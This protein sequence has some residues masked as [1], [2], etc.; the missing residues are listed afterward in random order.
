MS[1]KKKTPDQVFQGKEAGRRS[2]FGVPDSLAQPY[3]PPEMLQNYEPLFH[4]VLAELGG[5][6]AI[7]D[8]TGLILA[9]NNKARK[10]LGL[11]QSGLTG[12][13]L[14]GFLPAE[15]ARLFE[16]G[17]REVQSKRQPYDIQ[18]LTDSGSL[19]IAI[20]PVCAEGAGVANL[21]VMIADAAEPDGVPSYRTL[22]ENA[23]AA[24]IVVQDETS[25]FYNRRT[26]EILGYSDAEFKTV[27]PF[28]LIHPEDRPEVEEKYR[29]RLRG[30]EEEH[31]YD[32]RI[33]ARNGQI[34][35]VNISSVAFLWQGRPA[36]LNLIADVT[37][38]KT[39]EENMLQGEERYRFLVENPLYG[40]YIAETPSGGL[41]YA[42]QRLC[43][44][45]GYSLEE[46]LRLNLDDLVLPDEKHIMKQ[47]MLARSRGELPLTASHVFT[48]LKKDG[49]RFR[50][51]T[52]SAMVSY[53]GKP[54]IQGVVRDVTER[55]LLEKQLQQS[56]KM[57]ALGTLAG[58]VAH[59]F[60]NI[61]MAIRGYSQ[62][63]SMEPELR[64]RV[65]EY[66]RKIDESTSR[67]AELTGR[68]LTFSRTDTGDKVPVQINQVLEGVM[69]LIG[70]TFPV[71]IEVEKDLAAGLPLVSGNPNQLQQVILNLAVN[72]RDAMPDGGTITFRS[73]RA[74]L[75]ADF[76]RSRPWAAPGLYVEFS[77]ED[78]GHGV[79]SEII[80]RIF[81]PF[82]T[83]KE[84]GRGTGLGLAVAYAIVKRHAGGVVVDSKDGHGTRFR[85]YF[86][87]DEALA[88]RQ[89]SPPKAECL[90]A[91]R[92]QRIL[93]V[94]DEMTVREVAREALVV[95]GY[96][97]AEASNGQRAVQLY[98][99][100][101]N[102]GRPFD[103]VILDLAMP[104]MG[105][106]QCL[107]ELSALDPEVRIIIVT[108]HRGDQ[109]EAVLNDQRVAGVL[110]KPFDLRSFLLK[111]NRTL[112]N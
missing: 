26:L 63:L 98:Q 66:L 87:A 15:T 22:V 57:E 45:L 42:N 8:Q 74:V 81:E 11:E 9:I 69:S 109:L 13:R 86:P 6:A 14:A 2:I 10:I 77:I 100:A 54:A 60:N 49:T 75:N 12:T 89:E 101:M 24:V 68:M 97:V 50:A 78:T 3:A 7:I 20:K 102:E 103:L 94:D 70:Q 33:I 53:E 85:V 105:G 34:K 71:G 106:A 23:H 65:V 31:N 59:E 46:T 44:M 21:L 62:L 32:F 67:A 110:S 79:P 48:V 108:G 92:G 61:L 47:R 64:P 96:Q 55:E 83:T 19:E 4:A 43:E 28:S 73:R 25:K 29:R 38:R 90:P 1:G 41:L 56:Q 111:V 37:V 39:A 18:A 72:A 82:F 36:T 107:E 112:R 17:L 104:V 30:S 95:Y 93:I 58:G 40:L 27:S 76:C 35:W 99:E 51:E 91:G 16:A 80:S 5:G 88:A 84:P 52:N